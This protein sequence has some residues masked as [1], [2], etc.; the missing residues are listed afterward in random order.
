MSLF[1]TLLCNDAIIC[2][3]ITVSCLGVKAV[4]KTSAE[5]DLNFIYAF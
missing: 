2:R 5:L 4:P 1:C 3:C